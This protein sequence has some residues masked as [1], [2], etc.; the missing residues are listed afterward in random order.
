MLPH[1][2]GRADGTQSWSPP[3]ILLVMSYHVDMTGALAQL[4]KLSF[5]AIAG[6]CL[7][8]GLCFASA[9]G[10]SRGPPRGLAPK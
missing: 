6:A 2:D 10:A 3:R 8:L 1:A 4:R 5:G 9:H 7:M